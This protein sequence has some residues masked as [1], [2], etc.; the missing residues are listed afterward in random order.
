MKDPRPEISRKLREAEAQEHAW[1]TWPNPPQRLK[2]KAA[3]TLTATDG[4]LVIFVIAGRFGLGRFTSK[5]GKRVVD[6]MYA[7]GRAGSLR[8]V[9]VHGDEVRAEVLEAHSLMAEPACRLCAH[10]VERACYHPSKDSPTIT[11]PSIIPQWCPG[12][13]RHT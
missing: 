5:D 7:D 10:F 13:L 1:L 3:S 9:R 2:V 4:A 11:D 6:A 8:S 12:F